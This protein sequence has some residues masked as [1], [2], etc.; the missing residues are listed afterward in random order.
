MTKYNQ[1]TET[2]MRI[3]FSQLKEKNQRHYAALEVAKLSYGGKKYIGELFNISQ[4]RI[5]TG[6]KELNNPAL[7][8]EIPEGKQR[9]PGGGRKK[10]K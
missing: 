2:K 1:E 10:K 5:R 6:E 4:Y 3:H 9:R 7:F 8:S